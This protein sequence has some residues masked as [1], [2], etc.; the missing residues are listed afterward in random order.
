ML[1][2][3]EVLPRGRSKV[4]HFACFNVQA[5]AAGNLI[6]E[7]D[8]DEGAAEGGGGDYMED[9]EEDG[10]EEEEEAVEEE[11]MEFDD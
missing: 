9:G 10:G 7:V 6:E 5:D 2:E 1:S 4:A 8:E 11:E 3:A